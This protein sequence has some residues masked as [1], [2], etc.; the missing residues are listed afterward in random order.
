MA[1]YFEELKRRNVFRVATAYALV[2][3]LGIEVTDTLAPRM[4]LPEWVPG[5]VILL[6]LVGFPIALLFSWAFE[7][8][9]EGIKKTADVD[10]DVSVTSGS[11]EKI[12]YLIIA[13]LLAVVLVQQFSP[14]LSKISP[15]TK[16]ADDAQ[17]LAIAV[18]PFADLSAAGDQEYLGDGV[19]EEIL[20]ALAA[21][22]GLK[23]TSRTSA[24]AFKEQAQSIPQIAGIL[25][26]THVVEG[27][28]RKQNDRVRITAQLIEVTGDSHLWS[29]TYDG[30]LNDIFEL[31]DEIATQIAAALSANL[32]LALPGIVRE[33]RK[34]NVGA[35]ELYL[36]ARQLVI[37]REDYD[38]VLELTD[39]ALAL[40]P[41][42]A[43]AWAEKATAQALIAFNLGLEDET[44][45]AAFALYD[46]AWLS[47][48]RA[49]EIEPAHPLGLA[50]QGLVRL[51]QKRWI[52][53]H[54]Y[55]GRAL[56]VEQPSDYAYLWLGILQSLTADSDGALASFDAGLQ[57]SPTAPNLIRWRMRVLLHRGEWD[58]ILAERDAPAATLMTDAIWAQKV[59][60]LFLGK[61]NVGEVSDWLRALPQ[62]A[63]SAQLESSVGDTDTVMNAM[64]TAFGEG[65]TALESEVR[66]KL[67][68]AEVI[69]ITILE[70]RPDLAPLYFAAAKDAIVLKPNN[71]DL[72]FA[73]IDA[74]SEYRKTDEF[75][76]LIEELAMPAYWDLYGWPSMCKRIG[77]SDFSCD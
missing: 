8:T 50:V 25:G 22:D 19:A 56:A 49:T 57:V 43:D 68:S 14:S 17:P 9:P 24:F 37:A 65:S 67:T 48:V 72:E 2:G 71:N 42:F 44:V 6:V 10:A 69:N 46:E 73:W 52:E 36:Q 59:A 4:G 39:A 13:A 32:N 3:W 29:E 41:E 21:V 5:L 18:L 15:F 11:G 64:L 38:R 66:S 53:A 54:V 30:D 20:N 34:W 26:V 76:V 63:D 33:S 23:V 35:Y 70:L 55:F 75:K 28:I 7:L 16:E 47:A 12:N 1:G 58:E 77:V 61:L 51:N 60:G 40:E 45:D 27:S 62:N 74:M 31:Q